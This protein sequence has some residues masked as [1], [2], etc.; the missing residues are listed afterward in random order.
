MCRKNAA[1]VYFLPFFFCPRCKLSL[2]YSV[3]SLSLFLSHILTVKSLSRI[4]YIAYIL[5]GTSK[6]VP[7]VHT[8]RDFDDRPAVLCEE[9]EGSGRFRPLSFC[10]R[11][12]DDKLVTVMYLR[13]FP[14][15]IYHLH[16]WNNGVCSWRVPFHPRSLQSRRTTIVTRALVK[17][18]S[19]DAHA[20]SARRKRI[21][22]NLIHGR[23]LAIPFIRRCLVG[24]TLVAHSRHWLIVRIV[25]WSPSI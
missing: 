13:G 12:I 16:I 15:I 8:S 5:P 25:Q 18:V 17:Y 23:S 7:Q 1:G 6:K 10:R 11:N 9:R 4:S 2:L 24:D 22:L 20:W 19:L 3:L 21:Q 14:P